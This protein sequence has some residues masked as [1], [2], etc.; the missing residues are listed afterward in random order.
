[1]LYDIN[2]ITIRDRHRKQLGNIDAL[3]E[4]ISQIGLLHPIVIKADGTLIAGERRLA[5]Y[6]RLGHTQIPA[7]IAE[8]INDIYTALQAERDENTCRKPFDPSE[9]VSVAKSI[10]PYEREAA[11]ERQGTRTDTQLV[12][13]FATSDKPKKQRA[14][15]KTAAAV[16]MGR[17]TLHKAQSIVEAADEAPDLFGDLVAQMDKNGKVDRAYKELQ[18]RKR[19]AELAERAAKANTIPVDD[20]FQVIHA[21]IAALDLGTGYADTIITDPPYP[22]EYLPVYEELAHFAAY[23]LKPGGSLIVMI[24]Q[25]YL[26]EI[27][28][29]MAPV[30]RYHWTL[31]YLTPGGQ[32]AQLWQRNVNTFWKPVLWFVNGDYRGP[33]I[34][35]VTKSA[36]NDN[37]KRYHVWGQSESGMADLIERFTQPGD[38]IVDPFCGAGTTG[39]A[40]LAAGRRFIGADSDAQAVTQTKARLYEATRNAASS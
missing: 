11:R 12:A 36:T 26:P 37:D 18:E 38:L 15:D 25:S 33:W 14:A 27:L 30:I 13:N 19:Q 16:G 35:D 21:A 22:Q 2:A 1:M 9:A 40:A 34:G 39:V 6:Q 17:D 5:A 3:A 31:A 8:H 20:R 7:T 24:G 28:A 29:A 23:T 4:S 32:S 10:E